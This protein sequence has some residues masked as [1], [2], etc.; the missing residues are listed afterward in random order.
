MLP[1]KRVKSEEWAENNMDKSKSITPQVTEKPPPSFRQ[2]DT[3]EGTRVG[4]REG[5]GRSPI[6]RNRP[7]F[8]ALASSYFQPFATVTGKRS[9]Q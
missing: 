1:K 9:R 8:H 2:L 5:V 7:L 4:K 3:Y 6:P